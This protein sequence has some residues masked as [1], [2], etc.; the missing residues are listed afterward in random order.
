MHGRGSIPHILLGLLTALTGGAIALSLLTGP[1]GA[2]V[3]LQNA[4]AATYGSPLGTT[5]FTLN[6]A[7]SVSTSGTSGFITQTRRVVYAPSDGMIVYQTQPTVKRLGRVPKDGISTVLIQYAAVTGGPS[8]WT[9]SGTHLIRT[10]TLGAFSRRVSGQIP[11]AHG[12]VHETAVVR[13][14]YLVEVTLN[15][16]VPRQQA[17]PG[18]VINQ[19][20]RILR[21]NGQAAPALSS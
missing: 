16:V 19:T 9:Q 6:L 8:D 13:G 17:A 10:E 18:D 15:V 1:P 11:A 20:Y 7:S 14:G 2:N 21:V 4:T 5:S 12:M 3:I